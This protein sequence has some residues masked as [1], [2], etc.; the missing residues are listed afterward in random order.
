MKTSTHKKIIYSIITILLIIAIW[1][2]VAF[3]K[4]EPTIFPHITG[5]VSSL[6]NIFLKANLN[7]LLMTFL[8]VVISILISFVL[9]L[10][11]G[12]LYINSKDTI[13][14]FKPIISFMR[15][16]PQV[17]LSIFLFILFDKI[18]PFLITILVIF[19]IATEG[20]ITSIDNIDPVL[21]DDLK[22]IKGSFFKKIF[23]AYIPLIKDYLLMV[24]IQ[25]F[26]LGF[27][28]MIMGEYISYT[29]NSIGG[30]LY[31]IKGIDLPELIAW[32][33]LVTVIV[34]L[35]ETLVKYIMKYINNKKEN[36]I[37][38]KITEENE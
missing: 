35:V 6:I 5:I 26:G 14:F 30:Y 9:S 32:G 11:V 8:R 27:K 10:I 2:I 16:T 25:I 33:I 15:S 12:I 31:G 23:Y 19:P 36:Y 7:I 24:F 17:V 29:K 1:E 22:M 4:N 18:A 21:Q 38:N 28:V 20:I 13:Y 37:K 34:I 3:V